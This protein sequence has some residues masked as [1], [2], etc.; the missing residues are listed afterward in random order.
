MLGFFHIKITNSFTHILEL[1]PDRMKSKVVTYIAAFDSGSVAFFSAILYFVESDEEKVKHA[2]FWMGVGG[3]VL[4]FL[5][6]PESPRF[7]LM[8]RKTKQAIN[9]LNYIAWFNLSKL[10]IPEDA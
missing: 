7:L 2:W 5:V 8:N 3:V 9:V 6:V 4:Y 10:R 1:V